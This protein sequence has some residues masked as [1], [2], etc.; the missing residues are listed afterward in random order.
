MSVICILLRLLVAG[1]QSRLN[2]GCVETNATAT[3]VREVFGFRANC[4]LFEP[5]G[6]IQVGKTW[7][8]TR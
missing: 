8:V 5:C 4:F 1:H 6:V 7:I 3:E 2:G